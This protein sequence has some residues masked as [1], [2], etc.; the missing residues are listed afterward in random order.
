MK[1]TEDTEKGCKGGI[2]L[3]SSDG[4]GKII[5]FGTYDTDKERKK[6]LL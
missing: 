4:Y 3:D 2:G 5:E 1:S 6:I